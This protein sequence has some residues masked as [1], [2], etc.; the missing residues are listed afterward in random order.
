LNFEGFKFFFLMSSN[1]SDTGIFSMF[2]NFK[3]KY[4]LRS[5]GSF[6]NLHR[7]SKSMHYYNNISDIPSIVSD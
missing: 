4:N 3:A 5:P 6:E 7:E 2:S 1:D